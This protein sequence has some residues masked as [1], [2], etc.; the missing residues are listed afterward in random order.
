MAIGG[1]TGVTVR[2]LAVSVGI[3][4]AALFLS[5]PF[6][7]QHRYP[8]TGSQNTDGEFIQAAVAV[9]AADSQGPI[10]EPAVRAAPRPSAMG[11]AAEPV[12][13]QTLPS[14]PDGYAFAGIDE[15][16]A[17][18]RVDAGAEG[19]ED[20]PDDGLDWLGSPSS[21]ET[22]V[23]QAARAGRGWTF[24]WIRLANGVDPTEIASQLERLGGRVLGFSGH[25][26][27][28]RLPGDANRL[29]SIGKLRG[30]RGLGAIPTQ[31]KLPAGFGADV[32]SKPLSHQ[33]AVFITLMTGDPDGRWRSELEAVGAA[34]GRYHPEIRVYTANVTPDVL[35][36]LAASD[37]IQTIEPVGVVRSAHNTAVPAMGA[38]DLRTH[39]GTR[40]LFSGI[41]GASTPIGV[42]DTG[43]N[44]NH[45]DVA[46]HRETICGANFVYFDPQFDDQ[47]LWV[48]E[49]GHGT[50]V[51]GTMAGNGY[52]QARFAGMA[53]SVGHIRVAKVL[54]QFGGGNEIFVLRGM[55]FL[56]RATAC[57]EAGWADTQVK[58][59]VV[60]ASLSRNGL[61]FE[62]RGTAARKL[63][64]VVWSQGQLYVVANSNA[65][66]HGFSN[67]GAAK[68]SLSVGAVMDDGS[69][70]RFSS[71][72]PT[73][74]GRL[75]PQVVGTGVHVYSAAGD[76][77]RGGYDRRS[78]TSMSSPAVA[79]AAALMLDAVAGYRGRPAL[80]RARLMASAVRPDVWLDEGNG[81]AADNS[82]GPGPIQAAYGLGKVSAR[83]SILH[84]N[85]PDGWINRS[86]YSRVREGEYTHK[87]IVVP[88]GA[89]RLDL[90][91]TWDEQPAETIA[92]AVLN[93][94]DL[95]L[96]R[97]GD[98]E[99]AA[100]G[101]HAS[102]S[103][104]D[105][106]E[107]IFIRDPQPGVYRA[108]IVARRVY[109]SLPRP[110]LA[111]TVI[112]GAPTPD[113]EV[114]V[115]REV[116]N[117][118]SGRTPELK[119][120][121]RAQSYVSAGT[122]LHID[123]R[124]KD[125][126]SCSTNRTLRVEGERDDGIDYRSDVSPGSSIAIGELAV[127]ETWEADLDL[128]NPSVGNV[129]AYRLYFTANA[130]NANP[131]TTSVLVQSSGATETEPSEATA[132][133]ND[134]F[135]DAALLEG[136]EGS[137]EIDLLGATPEPGEPLNYTASSGRP[138]GSIWYEWVA[139]ED[140]TVAF[141]GVRT[142]QGNAGSHP[143]F[144][145]FLGEGVA[146][147]ES[148]GSGN[149]DVRFFAEQG[150]TYLVRI[151]HTGLAPDLRLDWSQGGRPANDD[152]SAASVIEGEEGSVDGSN[153]GATLEPGEWYGGLAATTWYRW[154]APAEGAWKFHSGSSDLRV[155][156]F[157][158][159]EVADLRLVSGFPGAFVEFPA[160]AGD[161]YF[162]AVASNSAFN[163]GRAYELFWQPTE[164]DPGND[165]FGGAVELPGTESSS[166]PV[167]VDSRATVEPGEPAASGIRTR[168]W[169]WTAPADG[170]YTWLLDE[171]TRPTFGASNRLLVSVFEGESLSD[172]ELV[173]TNGPNM[174]V[175]FSF[176][177]V[178]DQRYWISV[179]LPA[180]DN[181]ALTDTYRFGN[182]TLAWGST[183]EN[184]DPSSAHALTGSSGS[185]S[186][187][188]RFATTTAG[189]R[190]DLLGH[191]SLWWT[192]EAGQTGWYQFSVRGD[193]AWAVVIFRETGDG[194]GA[195]EA[196]TSS[197]WQRVDSGAVDV[198]FQPR[199]GVRY[200]IALG[201][202]R[203]TSS[204]GF[205]LSW[206]TANPPVWLRYDGRLV[207]GDQDSA[208]NPVDV[209]DP[210]GLAIRGDGAVLYLASSVG[211]QVFERNQATGGLTLVQSLEGD[212]MDNS[213]IWDS[214]RARLLAYRCGSWQSYAQEGEDSEL[215]DGVTLT[216]ENESGQCS[217]YLF[218][219]SSGNHLYRSGAGRVELLSFD[220]SGDLS[221]VQGYSYPDGFIR[222]AVMG[223]ND[224]HV[225]AVGESS[226]GDVLHVFARDAETGTLARSDNRAGL[227]WR[228]EMLALSH[229]GNYLFVFDNGGE[230]TNV[231]G[232]EDPSLPNTISTMDRF[233]V[234]PPSYFANRCQF[235]NPRP[236]VHAVDIICQ[237]SAFSVNWQATDRLLEGADH[238]ANWQVDRF[239]NLV[240]EFG[241]PESVTAS[242]DGR[243]IYVAT[244]RH[245]ILT[246]ETIG[247]T[248][249]DAE[250]DTVDDT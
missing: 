25:L 24:A 65:G 183:P 170:T 250:S 71:L 225:Y 33:T 37:F 246:F 9:I 116:L 119:V 109:A 59:L 55:D 117:V 80:S 164:R 41:G 160:R 136:A 128:W 77:S 124:Q 99:S 89:K 241:S 239:N 188:I 11:P 205:T 177:A 7:G 167:D 156:A 114:A 240:P 86:L 90:V 129:G 48:D 130:W 194:S 97:D 72:G 229:D 60:N 146:A 69:L 191:S 204:G 215:G 91:L 151:S 175:K 244:P 163:T 51:T 168:W 30:V 201:A 153:S 2:A 231:F 144:D 141:A 8:G 182:A 36:L 162:I 184:D 193:G 139:P 131:A 28:A 198:L 155:M 44:I 216:V 238:L 126:G 35:E 31:A 56:A 22:L 159:D 169:S 165:D 29:E 20:V 209:R 199:A 218:M 23:T 243:F 87:D 210:A 196:V 105:N 50:H 88:E 234:P 64:S 147:L 176:A 121:V 111:W 138:A 207:D 13:K 166:Q 76:A 137:L 143:Q 179:G 73:A 46:S 113:L 82:D 228:A 83:T 200:T 140:G 174:S 84:R 208:G 192:F 85:R 61:I 63:D 38:D 227:V 180:Q 189:E 26:V 42:L 127:G 217:P 249:G 158:G 3:A 112:R 19:L 108:K 39:T 122:T 248:S 70:A 171:L 211:L 230:R 237:S 10:A 43:L 62:G 17:R 40:G 16:T 214:H 142:R 110:A 74:D 57:P 212:L 98:C 5:V 118:E 15:Q 236:L 12:G 115:D 173:A 75:L 52:V 181:S 92:N 107:W 242:P 101:E 67:Y 220:Q 133:S 202:R 53:P 195:L 247:D 150:Q 49:N 161:V 213:L 94:F 203:G 1:R 18:E 135:A 125:G 45:L 219:D 68:N 148:V 157:T 106:V 197:R 14:P 21:I 120:T 123:C 154:T 235:A 221:F 58:P 223:A 190:T 224:T 95:W 232:L 78:G 186:G 6:F 103:R 226:D 66:I 233:W 187:S 185:T 54:N 100:C 104:I 134:R 132:P 149:R 172:L 152:F 245:G 79:G 96:D 145:V 27:R 102:T 34:V 47:D 32:Q 4:A 222:N 206:S 93:D 81:F 178:A